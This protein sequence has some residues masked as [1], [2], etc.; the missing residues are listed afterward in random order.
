M[1]I[2]AQ[3]SKVRKPY[4][5]R[6]SHALAICS[7]GFYYHYCALIENFLK[8]HA[9]DFFPRPWGRRWG[10][11]G[12]SKHSHSLFL[13]TLTLKRYSHK[14]LD[15]KGKPRDPIGIP[16]HK[17]RWGESNPRPTADPEVFSERSLRVISQ[18]LASCRPATR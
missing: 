18:P 14:S 11:I 12:G 3:E 1:R 5:M 9:M 2:K 7:V 10:R 8:E 6:A 15:N 13:A 16:R 17:W 4:K